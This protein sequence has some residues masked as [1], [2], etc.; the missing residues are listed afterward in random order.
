MESRKALKSL[1]IALVLIILGSIFASVINSDFNSVKVS[2][3][4]FDTERGTLAANLYMPKG[5]GP[6][7]PRPVI[8]LTHGYLNSKEMQDATAVEMSRR[9]FIVLVVDQYDHGL[10]RWSADIPNGTELG[11]FWVFSMSDAVTYAYNQPYTLKDKDGNGYIGCSG[12]SMGGLSTVMAVFFDEMQSLQSGHRMIYAAIPESADF[13]FTN[14]VAPLETILASYG[15]RTMGIVSG[16]YDEF[17][18]GNKGEGMFYK[19]FINNSESGAVFLGKNNDAERKS[20]EFYDVPSG[21]LVLDGKTVRESQAGKHIV[22]LVNETHAQNHFSVTVESHI[23]DFFQTAFKGVYTPDMTLV[24][25]VSANQAWWLKEAGNFVALIGFFLFFVPFISLITKNGFLKNAVTEEVSAVPLPKKKLDKVIYWSVVMVYTILPASL[26]VTLT[27][28]DEMFVQV[29]GSIKLLRTI[30][31]I[32][33]VIML[34]IG[35]I[36]KLKASKDSSGRFA[37]YAMGAFITTAIS[38]IDILILFKFKAFAQSAYFNSTTSNWYAFFS[39]NLGLLFAIIVV[40]MYYFI[41]KPSGAGLAEYG[42]KVKPVSI[43]A[44]F[45]TAAIT[46]IAG[47]IILFIINNVLNVDFRIWT[48]AV[49]TFKS[50]HFITMLKYLPMFFVFYLVISISINATTRALKHGNLVAIL[51]TTGGLVLWFVYQYG[52]FFI[53]GKAHWSNS[54]MISIGLLGLIPSLL[55]AAIFTRKIFEKTHN[56][57]TAAFLNSMLFTMIQVANTILLWNLVNP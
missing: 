50:E 57:W 29:A 30:M 26:F 21:D 36:S 2:Q 7:N 48:F 19:D 20:G 37:S 14:N 51:S 41:N 33:A 18:F 25:M 31:I 54:G 10:S 8:V 17:F 46:V 39:L 13:T 24:N 35:I 55:I 12:H 52:T 3:L 49:K 6:N 53:T 28:I 32:F 11:T 45:L 56:V 34:L 27:N 1:A 47:Y 4:S 5:A 22:Y 44:A 38:V 40:M 15:N 16:H 9:G 23:I 42:L 43:F